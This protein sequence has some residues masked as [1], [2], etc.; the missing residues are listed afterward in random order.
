M[1]SCTM[2]VS[3]AGRPLLNMLQLFGCVH[4][5]GL[6]GL[7]HA[8][9]GGLVPGHRMRR[10]KP[11]GILLTYWPVWFATHGQ[12]GG[13]GVA[14]SAGAWGG[15]PAPPFFWYAE[16]QPSASSSS[17]PEM[18]GSQSSPWLCEPPP[19]KRSSTIGSLMLFATSS[20]GGS[21]I[22]TTRLCVQLVSTVLQRWNESAP[23]TEFSETVKSWIG[24]E[25]A[26]L[27]ENVRWTVPNE[28][29]Q[30]VLFLFV[31]TFVP[32]VPLRSSHFSWI[33]T[34]P[35]AGSTGITAPLSHV[36]VVPSRG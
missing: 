22:V 15:P 34:G 14:Q 31:Q 12:G 25:R 6:A 28:P 35:A 32:T 1:N 21:P 27:A 9:S 20:A 18:A 11:L 17:K 16:A 5:V 36:P 3:S 2:R 7:A 26:S 30:G 29:L 8:G 23:G 19:E 33:G 4:V 13:F 10:V 24:P